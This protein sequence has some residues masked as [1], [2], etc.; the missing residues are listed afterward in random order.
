VHAIVGRQGSALSRSSG[1]SAACAGRAFEK[2]NHAYASA[3]SHASCGRARTHAVRAE[4]GRGRWSLTRARIRSSFPDPEVRV[5]E[6]P[7]GML[8]GFL[9]WFFLRY[10]FG[11]FYT[12]GPSERAVLTTFG[13]A[14]RIDGQ[15]TLND[16]VSA[17]L[18]ADERERYA[19][20]QV[21]VVGPGFYWKLPWQR[22]HKVSVAT[23]TV[24]IAYDPEVPDANNGGQV[25]EAVTKDQLNIGL[26]GQLRYA[27]SERNLYAY[28]F[29]VKNSLAHVMGYFMSILR[30]RIANFTAPPALLAAGVPA[31]AV[32]PG[33]DVIQTISINDLRRHLRDLNENMN[34]ECASA[35]ARY[36]M[37]FDAALI[38]S[39]DPPADVESALAAINTAHN[40]VSSEISLAQATADQKLVMSR[41][42]VEIETLNAQAEVEPLLTLAAQLTELANEGPEALRAYLRNAGL[43]LLRKTRQLVLARDLQHPKE[44]K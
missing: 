11:G 12:V 20:P 24:S 33:A 5:V 23:R 25:L 3:V 15:T 8:F 41:R 21:R 22:V 43:G 13:R 27:V 44:A 18:R 39:I 2:E 1:V 14:A 16:P 10:G 17:S 36:G 32:A 35:A 26:S 9:F 28:L 31:E 37:T 40:Q 42:A 4:R 34:L 38:T 30:D 7:L 29:G 6:I 19:Y